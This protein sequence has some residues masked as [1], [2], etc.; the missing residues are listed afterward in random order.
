MAF[1]GKSRKFL[2]LPVLHYKEVQYNLIINTWPKSSLGGLYEIIS[3]G[4]KDRKANKRREED[5]K[6]NL[7]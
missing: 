5:V 2:K 1:A 7:I 4:R 3:L 6:G